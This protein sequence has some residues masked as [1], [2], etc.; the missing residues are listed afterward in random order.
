MTEARD[1]PA[2]GQTPNLINSASVPSTAIAVALVIV[3][4]I[5]IDD[6]AVSIMNRPEGSFYSVSIVSLSAL[7]SLFI[8]FNARELSIFWRLLLWPVNFCVLV[9]L[10]FA[11]NN[12]YQNLRVPTP[13]HPI[14]D[15]LIPGNT[16]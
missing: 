3:G 12:L 6:M 16:P 9:G 14:H 5:G 10:A 2:V 1:Q 4:S 13:S 11:G 8:T 15:Q 7:V